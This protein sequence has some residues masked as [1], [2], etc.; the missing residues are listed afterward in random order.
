MGHP[1]SIASGSLARFLVLAAI[2]KHTLHC[3]PLRAWIALRRRGPVD[4]IWSD[5]RSF[6]LTVAIDRQLHGYL[7][8]WGFSFL[9]YSSVH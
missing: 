9:R 7:S 1:V 3:L 4:L 6:S 2:D 5:T 8:W